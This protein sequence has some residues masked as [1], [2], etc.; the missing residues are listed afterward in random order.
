MIII[1]TII[2]IIIIANFSHQALGTVLRAPT[3][4][5]FMFPSCFSFLARFNYNY[6]YYHYYYCEFFTSSLWGPFQVRQLQLVSPSPWLVPLLQLLA[7][8]FERLKTTL[9]VDFK[10]FFKSCLSKSFKIFLKKY[11]MA[12]YSMV[13]IWYCS[14][15]FSCF[16]S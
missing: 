14:G 4:V 12:I 9:K 10:Y 13:N 8:Y 11:F 3:T 2:I 1:I 5:I 16:I 7:S 6:Y 15:I